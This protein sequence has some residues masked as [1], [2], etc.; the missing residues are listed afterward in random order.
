[1]EKTSKRLETGKERLAAKVGELTEGAD[2]G[3]SERAGKRNFAL[4]GRKTGG[5]NLGAKPE[6]GK[7]VKPKAGW[8]SVVRQSLEGS[9]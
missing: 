3:K 8:V 1:L 5:G 9:K 2:R 4:A 7:G 6:G